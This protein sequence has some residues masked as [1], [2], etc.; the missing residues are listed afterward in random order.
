VN[1]F[2]Y[3]TRRHRRTE[4]PRAYA[5]YHRYKPYLRREFGG[6]C[7]YCRL[8]DALKEEAI[9]HVDHFRPKARFP[10]LVADYENLLYACPACNRRKG[11]Y[12][13]TEE[14][15]A[16]GRQVANTC[17]VVM[18]KHLKYVGAE[19]RG[20]S[21]RGRFTVAHLCLNDERSMEYRRFYMGI[22]EAARAKVREVRA[23][24][25]RQK[26]SRGKPSSAASTRLERTRA[27]LRRAE[28]YVARLESLTR[29]QPSG[30]GAP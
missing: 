30:R 7:V 3:P 20:L 19:V 4:R 15:L 8:P 5:D 21:R 9:F 16:A 17:D 25:G 2:S 22:L 27:A 24:L 29:E 13:P 18:S 14:D 11:D 10:E 26:Q 28:A 23:L 12:W 6:Q 1:P